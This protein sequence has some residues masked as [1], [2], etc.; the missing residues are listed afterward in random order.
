MIC[1]SFRL[2]SDF[3]CFFFEF[4]FLLLHP[5]MTEV[6]S[7]TTMMHRKVMKRRPEVLVKVTQMA[8]HSPEF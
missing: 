6:T 8:G 4:L 2:F 3:S 1:S 5:M 7:E